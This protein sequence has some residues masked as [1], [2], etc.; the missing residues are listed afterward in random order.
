MHELMD[1]R[2][3]DLIRLSL[4]RPDRRLRVAQ[5]LISCAARLRRANRR[6]RRLIFS[7]LRWL[8][9]LRDVLAFSP[10][11]RAIKAKA[12]GRGVVGVLLT[13]NSRIIQRVCL[14]IKACG[15]PTHGTSPVSPFFACGKIAVVTPGHVVVGVREHWRRKCRD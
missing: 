2:R 5:E 6:P 3:I 4:R 15:C 11:G 10:V 14:I 12:V 8:A 1:E 13:E 7:S 9:D